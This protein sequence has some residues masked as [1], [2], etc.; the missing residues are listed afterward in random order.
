M[1]MH[2]N[3][4]IA[5]IVLALAI[6]AP[7]GARGG[8]PENTD[9]TKT[10]MARADYGRS[11]WT[12]LHFK[13]AIDTAKDA[14]CLACHKDIVDRPVRAK[15]PSGKAAI[16]ALAWYQ[17]LDTYNGDQ[18]NFH[19]RHLASPFA[20]QVMDLSCTFCHQG[21]D[22]REEVPT[23]T[24]TAPPA[25]TL[26][27]TVNTSQTCLRCHGSFPVEFMDGVDDPWPVARVDFEDEETP[28]GCLTCHEDLFRTVRHQVTYL[29]ADKIEELAQSGSDVC[30]GCHGGRQ[31]YSISFPYP[32]NPWP[33]MDEE[34]PEWAKGRPTR[35]EA[36]FRE[37]AQ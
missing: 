34:T 22:P 32:R 35:S 7:I 16:D 33:D 25:F 28:N 30:Y 9:Q 17:T 20:K 26:R 21:H 2:P 31:W 29:N 23:V 6:A 24:E 18:A 37:P 13:P 10:T 11:T 14:D 4:I 27:K 1:P 19:W 5:S 8:E 12:P 15:T 36:R 3:Q